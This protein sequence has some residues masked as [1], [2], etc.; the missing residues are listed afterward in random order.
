MFDPQYGLYLYFDEDLYDQN[1]LECKDTNN[2]PIDQIESDDLIPDA[3]ASDALRYAIIDLWTVNP[4]LP[5][6][7]SLSNFQPRPPNQQ[8]QNAVIDHQNLPQLQIAPDGLT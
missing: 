7:S 5:D 3:L 2:T 4:H 8:K 6:T 1:K